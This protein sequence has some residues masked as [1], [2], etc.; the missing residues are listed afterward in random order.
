M[1]SKKRSKR[2][3]K[4]LLRG[5]IARR[6][7]AK[8]TELKFGKRTV[9]ALP[10]HVV[11]R[12]LDKPPL[13]Y[14]KRDAVTPHFCIRV[15]PTTKTFFW[16]KTIKN[17]GQKRITIGRFP[18]INVEQAREIADDI[19]ADYAKGIDVQ[20]R[21]ASARNEMTLG[22]LW[23]DYREHRQRKIEGKYS[24]TLE[25]LWKRFYRKWE[26][27]R[28]SE[29]TFD[30]A[31]RMILDIRKRAP[32]RANRIQRQGQAMF[33]YAR[34]ELRW[35]G[36]NPFNFAFVSEKGR[37]RKARVKPHEMPQFMKGLE[38][39]SADMRVLFL[40]LLFTG[41]RVGEVRAMRWVDLDFETG[42]WTLRETK[43]GEEQEAALPSQLVELLVERHRKVKSE[44]VFPSSSK[45]RHVE[46]I[47][48][49]WKEVREASGLYHL[50]ARDLR[51]T[52]ASWA[53]DVNV[54]IA[55]VQAQLGHANISTTAKHY[56]SIDQTV[57]QR[58]LDKTVASMIEA[59]K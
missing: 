24:P 31:R 19:A 17:K 59:A 14:V 35:K 38:A 58:A 48:K 2:S 3:K 42:I 32:I 22:E 36:D 53:Q 6:E 11:D 20:E 10:L 56:T 51:R 7:E 47:K 41:R 34:R 25:R 9:G 18:E 39:C 52:L 57:Q 12:S 54:P 43:V 16:E 4:L 1:S 44:W 21:R 30:K 40:C 15:T 23:L 27:K 28:L 29:I 49:A 55:A 37:A 13:Y 45:S 50:Q 46:E 33:N 5:K 8:K 26:D